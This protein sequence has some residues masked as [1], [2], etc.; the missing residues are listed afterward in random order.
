MVVELVGWCW[1]H[2]I[3]VVLAALAV[4]L[5][6]GVY[7]A[8]TLSLDTDE[9]KLISDDLPFR[10]AERAVDQA[11]P[12]N[13]DT[14]AVVIDGPTPELAETAVDRLQAALAPRSELFL[15]VHRP[16][17]EMYFRHRGLLFL[18]VSELSNLSDRLVQAQPF[19]GMMA[20]DPSLRGF[21]SI[22][23]LAV[24]GLEHGQGN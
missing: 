2:P 3:I 12:H 6:L 8:Q 11:F 4:T 23:D 17:E 19:L 5:T 1:R 24:T 21:L 18:S 9:K 16:A 10:Q 22:V 15:A 14:I 20:R 13:A 7:A